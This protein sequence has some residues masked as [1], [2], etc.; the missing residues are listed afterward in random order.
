MVFVS[1]KTRERVAADNY[2]EAS[3]RFRLLLPIRRQRISQKWISTAGACEWRRLRPS[4]VRCCFVQPDPLHQRQ[5]HSPHDVYLRRWDSEPCYQHQHDALWGDCCCY[6]GRQRS[7]HGTVSSKDVGECRASETLFVR[8]G[9]INVR[10][11]VDMVHMRLLSG[12]IRILVYIYISCSTSEL[13][14]LN[15]LSLINWFFS[16]IIAAE[17]SLRSSLRV[18]DDSAGAERLLAQSA[19]KLE[20]ILALSKHPRRGRSARER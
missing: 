10:L 20:T 6:E 16:L 4:A 18:G 13:H 8:C 1:I 5:T 7:S 9:H 12:S 17:S 2:S 19:I 3:I 14:E 11:L 15:I